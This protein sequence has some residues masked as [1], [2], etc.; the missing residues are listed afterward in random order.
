M[1]PV[2]TP[3][4]TVSSMAPAV[5]PTPRESSVSVPITTFLHDSRWSNDFS[6][7][8][9]WLATHQKQFAELTLNPPNMGNIEVSL[10]IDGNAHTATASFVSANADVRESIE[11]A[12]PRLREMFANAGISLGETN[13]S[14]ESFRQTADQ[15]NDAQTSAHWGNDAILEADSIPHMMGSVEVTSMGN[16]L[17]DTF[18]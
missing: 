4:A 11:T 10:R 1:A 13:V 12:L 8:I 15:W 3:I 17:V 9:T 14:A 2:N 16:G 7:K 6:Q 5:V 18:V